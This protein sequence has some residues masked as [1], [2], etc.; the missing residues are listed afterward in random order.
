MRRLCAPGSYDAV[1]FADVDLDSYP[2][3]HEEGPLTTLTASLGREG[4]TL[5]PAA[6]LRARFGRAIQASRGPVTLA[7]VTHDRQA[8]ECYPAA[9]WTEL[10]AHAEA[11]G[12]AKVACVGEGDIVADFDPAAGEGIECKRVACEAPQHLSEA[13]VPYLILRRRDGEGENAPLVP[14]LTSASQIEAYSTCPLCWFVSYRVKPSRSTLALAI[15]RRATLSTTC[16]NTCMP[17]CPRRA[18]SA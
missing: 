6:L 11:A 4:V 9:V 8:R 18:W 2:L 14:R 10:R 13:A 3:S 1:L 7:R 15:W 12:A 17:V 16:W 5:E